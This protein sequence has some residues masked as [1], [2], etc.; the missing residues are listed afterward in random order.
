M[1][2]TLPH[3]EWE[4]RGSWV[5]FQV[6]DKQSTFCSHW[7]ALVDASA[8]ISVVILKISDLNENVYRMKEFLSFSLY[9]LLLNVEWY[10]YVQERSKG[11][12]DKCQKP[13]M[14]KLLFNLVGFLKEKI[15]FTEKKNLGTS[16]SMLCKWTC[17]LRRAHNKLKN[18]VSLKCFNYENEKIMKKTFHTFV[19]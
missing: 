10:V 15:P 18:S 19:F 9:E 2:L 3:C 14:R 4:A 12:R 5:S 17:L 11:R 1:L 7:W 6:H 13:L 8:T 16:L